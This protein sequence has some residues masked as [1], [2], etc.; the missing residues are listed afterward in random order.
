MKKALFIN[1]IVLALLAALGFWL[2]QSY[3]ILKTRPP[4]PLTSDVELERPS[5]L[6]NLPIS[7]EHAV[8]SDYLNGKIRG[9]F[10]NA[11]LWLQ[12]S[13]KERISLVLTRDE[14]IT[15]SSDGRKLFC[16]FPVSAEARLTDSRFGKTLAKLLVKPVRAKAVFT[17]STPISLDRN[18][19]LR[20]RFRIV[21]VRWE[22][23]PVVKIGPF[24]KN[25]R[26]DLD[27]LLTDNSRGLTA[28]LDTEIHKAASLYPTV[29]GV[30]KDLQKPIVLA[31]K[32]LPVWL[33]FR[34]NDITGNVAL[35]RKAIVCNTRIRTSMRV[36]TDT[37]AMRPSTR[38]PKFRQ[39]PGD[40][41]ST[42][43]DL[44][45]YAL[46]PFASISQHLNEFFMNRSFSRSGYDIVVRSVNAYGSSRGLSVA[47]MT[48]RDLKGH[49][50]MS[51]QPRYDIPTH[52]ISIDHFD[53]AID[54]GNPIISTGELI[55]HD[56]IRDSITTRLD[57][58]IGS[59]VDRLP[60]II[61]RAVSKAKAGRTIDLTIDSLAIRKC[62]IRVGRH[63]V[64]LLVN[65]TAKN[66]LRIKRIK[67]G[68]VIRIRKQ[69][70]AK[71]QNP[72]SQFPRPPGTDN[73]P[74]LSP[75]TVHPLQLTDQF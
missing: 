38:L 13:R 16:T 71:D 35:N 69:A 22:E 56:A 50:I 8:L 70:E 44:N 57:V 52:T 14:P 28:L 30:W 67:S 63:N 60:T 3:T 45:F 39:T 12:A 72:A 64:Y 48:D 34:C 32:P 18:W 33:H 73:N 29:R 61:T 24:R 58:H 17:F 65:A 68:K 11:D 40:S 47:I 75:V 4:V 1:G 51:G 10:L 42:I 27:S 41:I 55:L 53:Y 49:I 26:A 6:F 20:T 9:N 21:D 43:S 7:I 5:S 46:I 37:T 36:L 19:R 25:I 66:A 2:H 54:T 31:R 62:D 23:E 15:I 59:F 74:R